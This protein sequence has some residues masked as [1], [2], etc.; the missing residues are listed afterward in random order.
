M[1]LPISTCESGSFIRFG[2]MRVKSPPR[3][4]FFPPDSAYI[5]HSA[6]ATQR[7]RHFS[8]PHPHDLREP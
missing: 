8:P 4:V 3:V 6:E 1:K 5:F 7:L 2:L